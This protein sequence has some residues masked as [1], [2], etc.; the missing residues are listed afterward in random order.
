VTRS[1]RG[2]CGDW[3]RRRQVAGARARPRH[4][5]RAQ[6]FW[7]SAAVQARLRFAR[8]LTPTDL[9]SY[10]IFRAYFDADLVRSD[11]ACAHLAPVGRDSRT[12]WIGP[13]VHFIVAT[14]KQGKELNYVFTQ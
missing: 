8:G 9:R 4:R 7:V 13:D 11:P 10:A 2:G 12:C 14:L 5:R 3:G 1:V 6:A